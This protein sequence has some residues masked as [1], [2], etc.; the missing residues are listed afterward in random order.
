M[1]TVV[2]FSGAGMS[3]KSGIDTFRDGGGLWEQHRV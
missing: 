3:A 2:V 1:K